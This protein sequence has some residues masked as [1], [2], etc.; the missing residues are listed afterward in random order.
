MAPRLWEVVGGE[1]AGGLVVRTGAA[2]ASPKL[3]ERLGTGAEVQE[4]ERANERLHFRLVRGVGPKEGWVSLRLKDKPLLQP[5]EARAS[6]LSELFG[7][8]HELEVVQLPPN[9]RLRV[10]TISDIHTDHK[11]NME[12]FK[13]RLPS[14][15]PD[16][17]NVLLLP[18]D[19]SDDPAVFSQT[20]KMLTASFDMV[21]YTYG[22][23]DLW[24]RSQNAEPDSLAKLRT[25]RRTCEELQ[26][27][28]GPV[29]L[30]LLGR[31]LLLLPLLSFYTSQ[32]DKE[33]E[34][35]WCPEQQK[36]MVAWM[37]FYKI[38]WP[39]LLMQ[40]V[41]RREKEG[42][43]FGKQGTSK[44]ISEIFAEFNEP[45]LAMAE[46]QRDDCTV[47]S[48]SHYLP[49]QEL[50]PEKR[51]L[52][53]STLHK[54]SGSLALED[55]IRRLK[56]QVH[57][58]GHSHLTVDLVLE[59]QRYLQ[60]ALGSPKEQAAMTRAV[61]DTGI[62]VLFDS[63]ADPPLAPVQETF[64]GRYF[65]VTPR[66]VS[67][68]CPA[69]HVRQLFAR[70]FQQ[71][72]PYDDESYRSGPNPGPAIPSYEGL[73]EPRWRC[74]IRAVGAASLRF[75][76]LRRLRLLLQ[77]CDIGPEGA[78][79]L[80][81]PQS[82]ERLD[83]D[84]GHCLIGPAG[85]AQLQAPQNIFAL[86]P[87]P[88]ELPRSLRELDLSL[89][90]CGIGDRGAKA[91]SKLFAFESPGLVLP[92]A[93][94]QNTEH[95]EVWW[96]HLYEVNHFEEVVVVALLVVT[97]LT[98][99]LQHRLDHFVSHATDY[100]DVH[101]E[102]LAHEAK[103]EHVPMP[104]MLL[105]HAT[106]E[107][108]VLGIL[109]FLVWICERCHL[110]DTC[111]EHFDG[112]LDLAL[113]DSG[114][115]YHHVV[116]NT[117]IHLFITFMLYFVIVGSSLF[118]AERQMKK[119][120]ADAAWFKR[121]MKTRRTVD[122]QAISFDHHFED[123]TVEYLT[124][125]KTFLQFLPKLA[126]RWDFFDQKL[127]ACLEKYGV[128]SEDPASVMEFLEPFFPFGQY[129]LQN[130][131]T[132][133]EEMVEIH[134]L[135]LVGMAVV[136]GFQALLHRFKVEFEFG[137]V[138]IGL[139]TLVSCILWAVTFQFEKSLKAGKY[140]EGQLAELR[141]VR[142]FA[143][144]SHICLMLQLCLLVI[145]FQ[146]TAP[147]AHHWTWEHDWWRSA[148][149]S[150]ACIF[151]MPMAGLL[152]GGLQGQLALALACGAMISEKPRGSM[153]S[154]A[155][156]FVLSKPLLTRP[157]EGLSYLRS[158]S[159]PNRAAVARTARAASGHGTF[160]PKSRDPSTP[161]P[162][163]TCAS[164]VKELCAI[165]A[166]PGHKRERH[167][168]L[169]RGD[170]H[171]PA[172]SDDGTSIE[173]AK[174]LSQPDRQEA[175][176]KTGNTGR[177][178]LGADKTVEQVVPEELLSSDVGK[179]LKVAM[180]SMVEVLH[181][182][183]LG[184]LILEDNKDKSTVGLHGFALEEKYICKGKDGTDT[185]MP[186]AAATAFVMKQLLDHFPD[187]PVMCDEDGELLQDE[188]FGSTVAEFLQTYGF[189][190]CEKDQVD[191]WHR[192]CNTYEDEE[193]PSRY[194]VFTPVDSKKE[195]RDAK[196]FCCTLC[197]MQDNKPVM[198]VVGCPMLAF[199]HPS[200]STS[201]PS[202]SAIFY[203]VEG[204]GA[205]TQCVI[206]EREMGVY[207]GRYG[208]KGK[209]LK[210]NVSEKIRRGND[211]LY[212]ML[213]TEQ[214]RISQHSRMRQDIFLDSERIAKLLGSEFAKFHFIDNSIKYC[215]LA[216]GDEDISWTITQGLYDDT[217]TLR[218]TE[219]AAGALVAQES[220]AEVAD[221]DGKDIEWSGRVLSNRG[222]FATDGQK[223]PKSAIVKA[224]KDATATSQTLYE[225]RCE[226]RKEKAQM[227]RKIFEN[228]ASL[229]ETEEERKGAEVVR[230]R[231]L[232][233]LDN[234]E[235]MMKLTQE[236]MNRGV[237]ILGEPPKPDED[238]LEGPLPYTPI[239]SD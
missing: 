41:A 56:P 150:F 235:E 145:C 97:L 182:L 160:A 201:H 115:E 60:W 102:V 64:W 67:N 18:G 20:M 14:K 72:L 27:R 34:L 128:K 114:S 98:D 54:V 222:F 75:P 33:P 17:F 110:F 119:L 62:L 99:I 106:E 15:S 2:L 92:L 189:V 58:F 211:G 205:F 198:S 84:L 171:A 50:F 209:S 139:F 45:L 109:A 89:L 78:K 93:S 117:H 158:A 227:L 101:Q 43:L 31:K 186:A 169:A 218:T 108:T 29:E 194:W 181:M 191:A 47:L 195:F 94:A 204:K 163:E 151:I 213:G 9:V 103:N 166:F 184:T 239:K 90:R 129:I 180:E 208:M 177:K 141:I 26:V 46:M 152:L 206:M 238:A 35:A 105:N 203:A 173:E 196:Q 232:E 51:F 1:Q 226:K 228:M 188:A 162:A 107:L 10:A 143:L 121:A 63:A 37:D 148:S 170:E 138:W 66:D 118:M 202:G 127:G 74:G 55:Q 21:C 144:P 154:F 234:D 38:R 192:H 223:V 199:D 164:E 87:A 126:G 221:M 183:C 215:W 233:M 71:E 134:A 122:G 59:G 96:N 8:P 185:T 73:F 172:V 147:A 11:V 224:A 69:P 111:F 116:E 95:G 23:H 175:L 53:D 155:T 32:W 79:A 76:P 77:K 7:P 210:L 236:S 131:R 178:I 81:L 6:P 231:G 112:T 104:Q 22:N 44:A 16:V 190:D 113:P 200:R 91:G 52:V 120:A 65:R 146:L 19:V 125:R 142:S 124:M 197:L 48:F 68:D 70:V 83:L 86:L 36:E 216:R 40:E 12:W 28:T 25:L 57:V 220:G 136:A 80:A 179:E 176:V 140:L 207:M 161:G 133:L 3:D 229:A 225:Q 187:D 123:W 219:H 88:K 167:G 24:L 156:G 100:S 174:E 165:H 237:P 137:W 42:F 153:P 85:A 4:L 39:E 168:W 5:R 61:A 230:M 159:S 135:S 130:Y 149:H 212:D 214:L 82:L 13:K 193:K 49:R 157:H 132:L 217:F 30:R